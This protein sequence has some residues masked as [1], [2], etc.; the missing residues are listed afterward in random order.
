M[1]MAD[2]RLDTVAGC[3]AELTDCNREVAQFAH[4]W[5]ANAGKLK[6]AQ[7][8]YQR[9]YRAA[10][11]G[12]SGRNADERAAVADAAVEEV[13]PGLAEQIEELIGSVET[14]KR[15]FDTIER[16]SSNAQSILSAHR[17]QARMDAYVP[18]EMRP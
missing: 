14:C 15:H 10:M 8:K 6:A 11:R 1:P 4:T 17:E 7:A 18:P 12:T 3:I 16:R 2:L 13:A 9:L 5:A